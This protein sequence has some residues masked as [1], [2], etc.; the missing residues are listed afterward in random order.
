MKKNELRIDNY[1]TFYSENE[2]EPVTKITHKGKFINDIDISD[3]KP[4]LLTDQ[5]FEDFEFSYGKEHGKFIW[6]SKLISNNTSS[7]VFKIIV[8]DSG[9]YIYVG[10]ILHILKYVHELQNLYFA[11]TDEELKR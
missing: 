6:F 9:E 11:L 7:G 3:V 10:K 4:V 2:I 1:I 5:S 8:T